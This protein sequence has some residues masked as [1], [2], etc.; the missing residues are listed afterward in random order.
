MIDTICSGDGDVPLY[1][2][3]ADGNEADAVGFGKVV[4]QYRQQWQFDGMLVADAALYTAENLQQLAGLK[5]ISR[6]PLTLELGKEVIRQ[7]TPVGDGEE[8]PQGYRLIELC[9]TYAQIEQRWVVVE[10][11]FGDGHGCVFAR[12]HFGS[13]QAASSINCRRLQHSESTW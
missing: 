3:V 12:V 7:V 8:L 13:T 10:S 2:R 9:T 1:L 11:G 4:A 5:W 6:V